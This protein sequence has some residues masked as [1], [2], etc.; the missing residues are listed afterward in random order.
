MPRKGQPGVRLRWTAALVLIAVL[1]L[2]ARALVVAGVSLSAT[3]SAPADDPGWANVGDSGVYLGDFGGEYWVLTARHVGAG[4]ITLGSTTYS[5]VANS[6]VIVKNG[7][8][9][10]T[11]LLLF[12]ISADPGLPT[13]T[14]SS[15]HPS[16][17]SVV[18]TIGDGSSGGATQLFWSVNTNGNPSGNTSGANWSWTLLGNSTGSNA[19]GYAWTGGGKR[20]GFNT[21][22][23]LSTYNV[24]TGL[25][26]AYVADF[27][28]I[29]GESQGATGDS[30]GAVFFKNV[31]TWELVGIMGAIGGYN[32]QPA[33]TAVFGDVTYYASVPTYYSFIADAIGIPEPSEYA[34]AGGLLVLGFAA[35][36]R[37]SRS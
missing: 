12:R 16:A 4:N 27:D 30:G 26:T 1:A 3:S 29:V 24:G 11:D 7:D 10:N 33:S 37:K 36:G 21:L 15:S 34:A 17:G 8:N 35:W 13:L 18:T 22:D 20:Y 25:T 32:S 6:S 2:P 9:S 5:P 28:A 23:A 31:S 19:S 14:L